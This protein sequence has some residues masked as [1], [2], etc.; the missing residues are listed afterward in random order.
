MKTNECYTRHNNC[1]ENYCRL[2]KAI[3]VKLDDGVWTAHF[4]LRP[5]RPAT[6]AE[7]LN[8]RGQGLKEVSK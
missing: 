2:E 6:R 8:L 4:E 3:R 7:V 5:P 1:P